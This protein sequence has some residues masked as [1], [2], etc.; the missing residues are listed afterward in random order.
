MIA[1]SGFD[2]PTLSLEL[3]GAGQLRGSTSRF[4]RLA[5]DMNGAAD[6]DLSGVAVTDADVDISGAG[7]VK[8]QMAGGRLTGDVSG[9]AR[10]EY[11]GTVS[12]E[13]VDES[14][15]VNVRRRN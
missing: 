10:L 7:S 4:D 11:S 5:L 3:S 12:E 14:G 9:A 2:G 8:L 13:A 1:F 15:V 6:I